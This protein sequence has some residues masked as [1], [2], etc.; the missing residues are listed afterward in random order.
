MLDKPKLVIGIEYIIKITKDLLLGKLYIILAIKL[1]ALKE[2]LVVV[3]N[4][5]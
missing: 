5:S 2:Y 4:Y 3:L 1:K